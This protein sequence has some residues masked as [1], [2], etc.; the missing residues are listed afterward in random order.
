MPNRARPLFA[1]QRALSS[2][3]G[4]RGAPGA[5]WAVGQGWRWQVWPLDVGL[6]VWSPVIKC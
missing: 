6:G 2:Q 3:A 4:K 1:R 5:S